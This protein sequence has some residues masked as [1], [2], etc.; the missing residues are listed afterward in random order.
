MIQN[1]VDAYYTK[2]NATFPVK[3]TIILDISNVRAN[4]KGQFTENGEKIANDTITLCEID[5]SKIGIDSLKY[6][7]KQ[8][9]SNDVYV[10]SRET[11]NVYYA[12]GV[13]IG[14]DTYY[15]LTD[16]I[17]NILNYNSGKNTVNSPVILFEVSDIEWTNKNVDLIVKIP[18]R[19]TDTSIKVNNT[20]ISL[21][22]DTTSISGYNV[23]TIS[24]VGNYHVNITYADNGTI[25]EASYS[26]TNVDNKA[27][28]IVFN[29]NQVKIETEEGIGYRE[30][31]SATDDL[32]GIKQLKYDYGE[33]PEDEVKFHFQNGGVEVEDNIIYLKK[34]YNKVTVYVEDN[35]GNY[36]TYVL[37]VTI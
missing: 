32:S 28:N 22:P 34:E 37:D 24:K 19:Y 27:P 31:T 1:A 36:R 5:Y 33:Y 23:Y 35:A 12:L 3:D 7:R 10:L 9:G 17:K 11:G 25:K 6:G 29:D 2:N 30:I 26:V 21:T 18:T 14:S 4:V 15:S 13:K 16:D 20:T 8:D